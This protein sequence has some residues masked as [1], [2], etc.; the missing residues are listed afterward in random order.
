MSRIYG[1]KSFMKDGNEGEENDSLPA[2]HNTHQKVD[3]LSCRVVFGEVEIESSVHL[4]DVRGIGMRVVLE[5]KLFQ[6]EEGLLMRSLAT[7]E[8]RKNHVSS[9]L[10][11]GGRANDSLFAELEP[12]LS[13]SLSLRSVGN[14]H[15][16]D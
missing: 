16:F 1:E 12:M 8:E 10:I 6:V 14:R 7:S 5:E 11:C 2:R 3:Q 4:F 13:S 9:L 15:R